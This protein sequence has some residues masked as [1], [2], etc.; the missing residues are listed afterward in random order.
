MIPNKEALV[1]VSYAGTGPITRHGPISIADTGYRTNSVSS[2]ELPGPGRLGGRGFLEGSPAA[3][4]TG[5][6]A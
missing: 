1:P 6:L 2:R 5:Q 4:L 3:A